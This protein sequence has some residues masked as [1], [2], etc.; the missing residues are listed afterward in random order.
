MK[1]KLIRFISII[2]MLVMCFNLIACS[3]KSDNKSDNSVT[4]TPDST[5]S[6]TETNSDTTGTKEPVTLTFFSAY[7]DRNSGMGKAEQII[8]DNYVKENPYVTIEQEQVANTEP[9]IQAYMASDNMPDVMMVLGMSSFMTPLVEGGYLEPLNMA[10]YE[11]YE[12]LPGSMDSFTYNDKLYGLP[13]NTDFMVLFCNKALF[14]QNGVKIPTTYTEFI[15]AINSFNEKGV[16]PLSLPGKDRWVAATMFQ[17]LALSISGNQKAIYDAMDKMSFTNDSILLEAAQKSKELNDLKAFQVGN[18]NAD[19]GAARN[20][21]GQGKAAMYYMGAWEAGMATD[22]A[23]SDDFKKNLVVVPFPATEKG[24]SSDLVAWN[25]GGY[26]ISAKSKNKE[27]AL[28]LI[29]YIMAPENW[30]KT[31]WQTGA[32][33]P[34]QKFEQFNTG[35]E[36][37]VQKSLV[38]ILTSASSLSGLNWYDTKTPYFK[39]K[40]TDLGQALFAGATSPEDF[41]K[42]VDKALAEAAAE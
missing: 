16:T 34:A 6:N 29:N 3:N 24:K 22:E 33:L 17:Q 1:R 5:N 39:T 36:T 20:Y 38:S 18:I 7:P 41:L 19:Y 9:K 14:E 23:F 10:D 25:G 4:Q 40:C 31:A 11:S 35:S 26:A 32:C 8:L 42:E 21:F 2:V 27:E 15:D 13:K 30:A 37:E 12:F 28:K